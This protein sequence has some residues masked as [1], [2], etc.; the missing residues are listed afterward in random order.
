LDS[1]VVVT[2]TSP[3]FSFSTFVSP[4]G[5]TIRVPGMKQTTLMLMT[6]A[7]NP[8]LPS[9]VVIVTVAS[10]LPDAVSVLVVW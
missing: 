10:I 7:S 4:P 5:T 9:L 3:A 2:T 6:S 1:P 8:P